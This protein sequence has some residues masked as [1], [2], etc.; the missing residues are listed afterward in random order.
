MKILIPFLML[1][2]LVSC[3]DNLMKRSTITNNNEVVSKYSSGLKVERGIVANTEKAGSE[4]KVDG[5]NKEISTVKISERSKSIIIHVDGDQVYRYVETKNNLTGTLTKKV[6]MDFTNPQRELRDLLNSNKGMLSNDFLIL[7]GTDYGDLESD[8]YSLSQAATYTSSFNL[9]KSLCETTNHI[10]TES[11]VKFADSERTITTVIN[12]T[13]VC[14]TK[15]SNKQIKAID[16]KSIMYC[17]S[18][19]EEEADCNPNE[20]LSWLTSDL[21]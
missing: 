8:S 2:S 11:T 7:K 6:V 17:S 20:D 19:D 1:A 13:S 10:S 14:G 16:L 5:A 9:Y 12:E 21:N 18:T 3:N 4:L 15:Y